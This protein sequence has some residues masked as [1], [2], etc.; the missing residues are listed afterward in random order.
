MNKKICYTFF[1]TI[2]LTYIF[3]TQAFAITESEVQAVVDKVGKEA[4]TGNVL[5]GFYVP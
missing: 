5:Y 4:V 1:V 3:T 2:T